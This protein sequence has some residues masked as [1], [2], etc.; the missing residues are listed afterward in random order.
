MRELFDRMPGIVMA[1]QQN[2]VELNLSYRAWAIRRR[3]ST[4]W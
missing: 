1:E 2:P 4:S 3:A